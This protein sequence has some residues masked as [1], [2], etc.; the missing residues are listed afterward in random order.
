MTVIPEQHDQ[1]KVM[2]SAFEKGSSNIRDHTSRILK[3]S[4]IAVEE[5]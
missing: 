2:I 4:T 1:I 3:K 5:E